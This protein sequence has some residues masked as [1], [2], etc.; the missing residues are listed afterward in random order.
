LENDKNYHLD[1]IKAPYE[2]DLFS[3]DWTNIFDPEN[4]MWVSKTGECIT[5]KDE[6]PLVSENKAIDEISILYSDL[7]IWVFETFGESAYKNVARYLHFTDED[8]NEDLKEFY[9]YNK[10][11]GGKKNER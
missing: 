4:L 7:L 9:K 3:D 6:F 1:F 11:R 10:K 8:I 5:N 2:F